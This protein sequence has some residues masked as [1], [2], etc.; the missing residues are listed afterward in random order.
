LRRY[1]AIAEGLSTILL[2]EVVYTDAQ[3]LYC[4]NNQINNSLHRFE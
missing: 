3:L 1:R 2:F 4:G